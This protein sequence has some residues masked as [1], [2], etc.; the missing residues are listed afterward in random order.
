MIELSKFKLVSPYAFL[1]DRFYDKVEPAKFPKLIIRYRNSYFEEFNDL[2]EEEWTN[3]FGR[4]ESPLL[5]QSKNFA[6]RYHGHQFQVYNPDIGDGR[7]FTIAQFYKNNDLLDLGTKGSGVTPYSRSGDGRLTLK[8]GIREVLCSNY[9]EA[10]GVNTSKSIS[11]IETGEQLSRNDEPSPTRS[12]LLV[13]VSRS[14]LRIGTFQ[15]HSFHQD[16][17]SIKFLISGIG[18]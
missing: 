11:L 15:Y 6:M 2:S 1:D 16:F 10:L 14:H 3:L 8:G 4:F 18:K 7:G 9:L 12:S 17:Q 13:R 5:P